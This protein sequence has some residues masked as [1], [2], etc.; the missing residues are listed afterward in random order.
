MIG[1]AVLLLLLVGNSAVAAERPEDFAYG[2]PINAD[3]GDALYEIAIPASVYS[4]VTRADLGDIRVFNGQGEVV[5]YAL[6][7]RPPA[8]VESGAAVNL[9]VFPFYGESGERLEDL[10]VRVEKSGGGAIVSVRGKANV[11][12]PKISLRGYLLDA[13]GLQRPARALVLDWTNS[14]EGYVGKVRVDGSN[15]FSVWQPLA[16][17]AALV[18]LSFGGQR[19]ER[20]R[21]ELGGVKYRYLRISW[22][23]NQKP[24]ESLS[25]SAE[26]A[27]SALPVQRLW[28]Q[29]SGKLS[30]KAGEYIYD[31]GGPYPFDRLRV[32]L[33]ELNTVAQVQ[34]LSR[35]KTEQE[36]RP[37][38]R[39]V[40]Y[41][42]RDGDGEVTSPEI[43]VN[44]SGERY[45]LLRIDQKGGGIGAGVPAIQ[46][47]WTPQ[48]L[49][50][51]ARGN[52]PFQIV[53]GSAAAKP[54]AYPIESLIPGY[55]TDAEFKVRPASL[56]APITLA[57]QA[58]LR[59]PRDYKTW[60]LWA[61][62]I[63]GVLILAWMASRL[64]R[65]LNA[66]ANKTDEL[67]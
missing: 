66:P 17:D 24:L 53:Y 11:G 67:K 8:R 2:M 4:G 18:R 13:S 26:P 47:G 29:I 44:S 21:V 23:E 35:A 46:I 59:P 64:V 56:G 45:W 43:D 60:A 41:R 30:G 58:R 20:N 33:P 38:A 34:I 54:A 48:K 61:S 36:W 6:R 65:Q 25:A 15:D 27:A 49:V 1:R 40:A 19:L 57:G 32:E 16:H 50:F 9:P 14:A 39:A 37:M 22:A 3:A 63:L 31:L 5:P 28:Q 42:L 62:L 10:H 7:P 55:K 52:G 51:A 12:A